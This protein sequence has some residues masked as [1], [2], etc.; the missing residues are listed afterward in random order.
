MKKC[1]GI[2]ISGTNSFEE[3][4]YSLLN[5]VTSL[6]LSPFFVTLTMLVKKQMI[7]NSV[8]LVFVCTEFK[9]IKHLFIYEEN[10]TTINHI[11]GQNDT[12]NEEAIQP[13]G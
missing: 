7:R 11:F 6:L 12:K 4:L 2:Y 9:L 5:S 10:C 13:K 8:Q 1:I 3:S